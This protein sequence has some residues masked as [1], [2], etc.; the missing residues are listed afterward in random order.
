MT[1]V[2]E[3]LAGRQTTVSEVLLT[4]AFKSF[5]DIAVLLV[6]QGGFLNFE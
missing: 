3:F 4:Q 2:I 6:F 5:G 1:K